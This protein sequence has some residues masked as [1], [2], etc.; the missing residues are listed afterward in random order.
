MLATHE[1]IA[2]RARARATIALVGSC[3][4]WGGSFTWAKN[5]MTAINLRAGA[6]PGAA[7]GPMLLIAWR[8]AIAGALWLAIFPAARRGWSWRSAGRAAL[9]GC[10][11]TVAMMAQQLG[12]DR[13]S[14]AVSAFL[15]S[16]SILFV[17]L[18]MLLALRRPPPAVLWIGVAL[19]TA[20]IWLMTGATPSGFGTGE[21]LGLACS[22]LFSIYLLAMNAL[23]AR[24]AP[25][26]M[27]GAQFLVIGIASA[28]LLIAFDPSARDPR[29]LMIPFSHEVLPNLSLLVTF[30]TLGGFGLMVL[31]QPKLD[32]ARAALIYL[33]EPI[34]AAAYAWMF[35]GSSLARPAIAGAALILIANALVEWMEQRRRIKAP[36]EVTA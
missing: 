16:L 26:R 17:P 35:A 12:L 19:A 21:L 1:V 11:F 13:T 20:G 10:L 8:F 3:L 31:Y 7:L 28:I 25:W 5:A 15:T 29:V 33:T 4:F 9:L 23:V 27:A 32:P 24:D 2:S 36:V 34:F 6:A 18:L 30:A 22:I 14:E